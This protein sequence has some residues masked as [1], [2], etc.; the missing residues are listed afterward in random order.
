MKTNIY[1][2]LNGDCLK[3]QFP[4]EINGELIVARECLV[5]GDVS[6]TSLDEFWKNRANY[7]SKK[8]PENKSNYFLKTVPE[9]KKII[10][11]PNDSEINLWFEEDLFCQVNLW[12]CA[13]LIKAK[14]ANCQISLVR[15]FTIDWRGFGALST[16]ELIQAYNIKKPLNKAAIELL[17][18]CW[19][20]F[21]KHDLKLL[22]KLSFRDLENFPMLPEV[23]Q[24]HADRFSQNGQLGRPERAL[25]KI[26]EEYNTRQF[27]DIFRIFSKK[28]G[29][30]GF[31]DVQV[32]NIFDNLIQNSSR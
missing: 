5:E 18:N 9:F 14:T 20:A 27:G 4:K 10:S 15:P 31:G 21:K 7:L 30:Y 19:E 8:Y 16:D 23:V 12:F 11:I 25:L 22:K 2:I 26:I 3:E 32:K 29:I 1:H 24:A 28:E 6:G 17:S 13:F